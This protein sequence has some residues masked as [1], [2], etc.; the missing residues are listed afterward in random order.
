MKAVVVTTPG[1]PEVLR[2]EDRP[3][4]VPAVDQAVVRMRAAT[5][6][7]IDLAAPAVAPGGTV[8]ATGAVPQAP[9]DAGIAQHLV[10]VQ[11][12]TAALADLLAGLAT[13]ALRT[14]VE[15][16]VPLAQAADAHRAAEERGRRGKV[17][18]VP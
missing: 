3:D 14:R 12:D 18:L 8:V 17:V 4:P 15:R 5:V 7:P 2:L 10:L 13:G 16:T 9:A 6:N 1:G 11:Q